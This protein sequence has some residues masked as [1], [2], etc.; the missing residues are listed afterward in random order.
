MHLDAFML[1]FYVFILVIIP[2]ALF[3]GPAITGQIFE[4]KHFK[5]LESREAE[6]RGRIISHNRRTPIMKHPA[7]MTIVAGEV[8]IGADRFKTWIAGFRQLVGGK[9]G[10]LSP[11]VERARREA[12]LRVLESAAKQ[13][14]TEVGNIRYTTANLKWN[15]PKQKE[16]LISVMA[17][18]TAYSE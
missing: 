2:L 18:G 14:F 16:L 15:A 6:I 1:C 3:I 17:Y 9:M 10:S 13:G 7:R 8:C 11:V 12:L 5:E 4:R